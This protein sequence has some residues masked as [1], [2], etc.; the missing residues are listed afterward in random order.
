MMA[1]QGVKGK[2]CFVS[3]TL[4]YM[5]LPGYASYSPGKHALMGV[6]R[7]HFGVPSITSSTSRLSR[8]LAL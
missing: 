4:G 1:K 7:C 5:G 3:S 6:F 2:I 8:I